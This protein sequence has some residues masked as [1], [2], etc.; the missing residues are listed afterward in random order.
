MLFHK[1][2]EGA[3]P[4]L[5]KSAFPRKDSLLIKSITKRLELN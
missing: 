4:T 3:V 1:L 5:D 2:L